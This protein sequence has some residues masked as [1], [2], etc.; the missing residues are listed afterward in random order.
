MENN[1]KIRKDI[2]EDIA[3]QKIE[4]LAL[5]EFLRHHLTKT[6]H[7]NTLGELLSID[8]RELEGPRFYRIKD[9]T[10][11]SLKN[12]VHDIGYTFPNEEITI[13][14]IREY[15]KAL[16]LKLLEDYDIPLKMCN[17][18]Y[19]AGIYTLEDIQ[20]YTPSELLQIPR[21]GGGQLKNLVDMLQG[22]GVTLSETTNK[23]ERVVKIPTLEDLVLLLKEKP[24]IERRI[25]RQKILLERYKILLQ[26]KEAL[27]LQEALLDKSIDT[28]VRAINIENE[29][30]DYART[31]RKDD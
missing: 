26:E 14:E 17:P 2:P 24:N 30:L 19:L 28:V 25:E 7:I 11:Q 21:I 1:E 6:Y 18:L 15:K 29:D 4:D 13:L 31:R 9:N 27:K 10:L 16:G 20:T 5:S 3:C 8:Y 23:E 22:L 12:Y